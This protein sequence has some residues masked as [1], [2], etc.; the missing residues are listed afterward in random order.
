MSDVP[1]IAVV[2]AGGTGSRLWPLSRELY[3]KQF[4]QLSG[5]HSLLQTTLLRLSALACKD[6]LVITNEQHRFIV[7]EQLRQIDQLHDNIILEPCGRNTAPAIALAAFSALK[8]NEQEDPLLLVLAADHVIAKE[9][10]FCSAIKKAVPIAENG[11]IVTF[12]IIPEYAETGYG[13]IERGA[14]I[15]VNGNSTEIDFYHV[16]NFVEKPD[17]LTAEKYISTGNYFWNSGMFMFKATVYLN[18]L[19]KFRPDI[20]NVC[21]QVVSASYRDLDFIRIPEALFKD[22]P[23]ESI[24]FAVM[25]KTE[26]CILCPIDIGWSDVGSWQSL[27]DISEKTDEGDVCKGDILTYNTK[28]NYIYSESALVAAVG[29]EDIVIVQTKDAILVSKKSDVQDVKKIVEMLKT[30]DRT[31]YIAHREVF[32]PW[33]KF[34]SIDQGERYRVKKI[35]VKP[36]EGLSLRMHHHRSEHWIV[37][38]GTAKVTLDDKTMLVTANESIYI[39][40]GATYSLENPGVIPLNL[41]EVSSGDYLGEDDIV[42]QKERYKKDN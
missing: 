2:M 6:P 15:S 7:A 16:K 20:Y 35:I 4:L 28:N 13:Y 31:E 26:H 29:V 37:L 11:N 10:V 40:L 41:I 32:R 23:A 3:P 24:D 17:R 18:E 39:P 36:G 8:R 27:W 34:D 21:E 5:E 1:L 9:N 14:P 30:Q 22:C 19:K 38:S 25:E 42:R 12:G 33:G